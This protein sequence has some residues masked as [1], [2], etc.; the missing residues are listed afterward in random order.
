MDSSLQQFSATEFAV[1]IKGQ[2]SDHRQPVHLVFVI[3][4]SD[5]M[6][7]GAKLESVKHSL[8][9]I[10]C[11]LN[12]EDLVSI[13]TFGEESEIIMNKASAS[14]SD[15]ILYATSTLETGGCTNLSAGL[16]NVM[17]CVMGASPTHKEGVLLLTD[18]H[19]NR[20]VYS[21]DA[22]DGIVKSILERTPSLTLNTVGY[23]HDHNTQL[24]RDVAV[25]GGG[26]YNVVYNLEGVATT[27]GE[28][29]G[30]MT[31]V[32]AQ[33][34]IVSLPA[35]VTVNTGYAVTKGDTIQVRIGDVYAENEIIVLYDGVQAQA[36][37]EVSYHNM[38]TFSSTSVRP[39]CTPYTG[40]EI[41][42]NIQQARFRLQ[43]SQILGKP[44]EPKARALLLE[45][46]ALPYCREQLIQMMI[47][48]LETLLHTLRYPSNTT[49]AATTSMAQHSAYLSL[50]RGLRS[51]E[52]ASAPMDDDPIEPALRTAAVD[53]TFS[54]FSNN[55][56]RNA[57]ANLRQSS[58]G[59]D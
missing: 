17:D 24:L 26:S 39:T 9:F 56:Q 25:Q 32:V 7:D 2:A 36:Q 16:M 30:G 44:D 51:V 1:V 46:K 53:T 21:K 35:G 31:T 29:L 33:N 12:P 34:V 54:P 52:P 18:G 5:S 3:D 49:L 27:F 59:L 48:D 6:N 47:D 50:G 11:L 13:I 42:K 23:G 19:A 45:L 38:L 8:K 20:G 58:Q 43:V 40:Q 4:T 41:P 14:E 37:A 10:T 57:T 55:A 28:I 22:L 15:A